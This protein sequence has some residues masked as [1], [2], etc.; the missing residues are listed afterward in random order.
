[1]SVI[2]CRFLSDYSKKT[3]VSRTQ[4][5]GKR[6]RRY[7][8]GAKDPG[9]QAAVI[10]RHTFGS[11]EKILRRIEKSGLVLETNGDVN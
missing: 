2:G 9:I 7:A 4:K 8:V 11:T 1:M 10:K 5:E 6:S 3:S